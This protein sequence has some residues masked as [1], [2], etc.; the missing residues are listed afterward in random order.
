MEWIDKVLTTRLKR[1]TQ[2]CKVYEVKVDVSSLSQK[3]LKHLDSIFVEAK[4]FYNYALSQKNINDTNATTKSVPVKVK[5]IFEMR[6]FKTLK[7]HMK[8]GIKKRI[9][10]S[11]KSLSTKKKQGKKVGWLKFKSH[12]NS[13][14]LPEYG[15]GNDYDINFEKSTIRLAGLKQKLKVNGLNQI[16]KEAEIVNAHFIKN[17]NNYYFH[18]TT[19]TSKV[20]KVVP[21]TSIGIDFGCTTQ[22]SL[23]D[24][25]KIEFQVPV[26][27][28]LKRLDRKIS[29]K[30]NG[31][32][33]KNRHS[34]NR[35]K[36]QAKRRKEYLRLTNKKKDIRNKVINAITSNFKYVCFQDE[37]IKGWMTSGHGK[38]IQNSG[39]GGIIRDLKTKSHTPIEVDKMFPSTQLCPKCGEKT[40]HLQEERVYCCKECQYQEDRDFHA[41]KNIEIEGL[42]KYNESCIIKKNKVKIPGDNRNFKIEEISSNTCFDTLN[43]ISG[44][45]VGKKRSLSQ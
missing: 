44:I 11:L 36:L 29:K 45:K 24:G 5:G 35:S 4:W 28:R 41:A 10:T 17:D 42:K 22:L 15:Y 34:K 12:I 32:I 26:S 30:V 33:G 40:K 25:T 43:K 1:K 37:S 3:T 20:E 6:D 16:P 39:I 27:E 19:F 9:F 13:I 14:P 38:K 18:I 23:S 31:K 21:E 8:Q 7:S 2:T